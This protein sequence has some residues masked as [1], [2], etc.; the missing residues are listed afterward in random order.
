ME[1]TRTHS[2]ETLHSRITYAEASTEDKYFILHLIAV[3]GPERT[4]RQTLI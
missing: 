3:Y 4:I 2:K 1:T